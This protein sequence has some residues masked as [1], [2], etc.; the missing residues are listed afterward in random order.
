MDGGTGE[1][2]P[3]Q[4]HNRNTRLSA[5]YFYGEDVCGVT[6]VHRG[7]LLLTKRIPDDR[8]LIV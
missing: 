2:L 4:T 8:V 5:A 7:E 1:Q 6:G 3:Q